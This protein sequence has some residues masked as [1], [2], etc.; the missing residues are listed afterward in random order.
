M[1]TLPSKK[2]MPLDK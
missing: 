2:E 1:K